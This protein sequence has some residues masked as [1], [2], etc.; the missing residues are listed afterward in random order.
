MITFSTWVTNEIYLRT[1]SRVYPNMATYV[2]ALFAYE[3]LFVDI[4]FN[5]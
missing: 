2:Y 1:E 4:S 3:F 5:L